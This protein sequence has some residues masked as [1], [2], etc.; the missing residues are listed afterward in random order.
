[1]RRARPDPRGLR[2]VPEDHPR[3]AAGLISDP[4]GSSKDAMVLCSAARVAD[5][6]NTVRF[7]NRVAP[8]GEYLHNAALL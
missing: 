8:A 2:H 3:L 6:M 1:V 4:R 5:R 7:A